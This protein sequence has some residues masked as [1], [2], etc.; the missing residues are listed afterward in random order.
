M[1]EKGVNITQEKVAD[2]VWH[3][4]ALLLCVS[5]HWTLLTLWL[6]L[7]SSMILVYL[8]ERNAPKSSAGVQAACCH[9]NGLRLMGRASRFPLD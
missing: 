7:P 1:V 2:S 9:F 4:F 5:L 6:A 3:W 8:I